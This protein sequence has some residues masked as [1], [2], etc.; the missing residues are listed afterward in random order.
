MR[1]WAERLRE[2]GAVV[3]MDYPYMTEGRS[4]P[5]P[6]PKLIA[7]HREALQRAREAQPGG[8]CILIG[9]SMGSRIGCHVSLEEPV[10]GLICFGYPLCGGGDPAKLRD[11]V[12]RKLTTP[13]LFIQGTRDSLCPLDL[14]ETI[15]PAL[16]TRNELHVVSG[17][18]HS[19]QVTKTE[20]KK[21]GMTQ[22]SV[23]LA[24]LAR[25]VEFV[26]SL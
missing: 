21:S 11:E 9:K 22:E 3:T 20:L 6:L 12:L 17:G 19:L 15:R 7:A 13:I 24:I 8:K 10:D 18:D 5:D 14:L 23:D 1:A 16:C 25:I 2:V 4:R 26:D